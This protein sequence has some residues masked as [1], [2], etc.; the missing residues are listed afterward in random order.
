MK[1]YADYVE[2]S[3]TV[4]MSYRNISGEFTDK[5]RNFQI[6]EQL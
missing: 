4:W 3:L 2:K 5:K 1:T 6:S